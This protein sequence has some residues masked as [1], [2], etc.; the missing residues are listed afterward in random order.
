MQLCTCRNVRIE[1]Q[2]IQLFLAVFLVDR[3]EQHAAGFNAHHRTRGEIHNRHT[4]LTDQLFRLVERVNAGQDRARFAGAVVQREL[5]ELLGLRDCFAV[6]NLDRAEIGLAEGLKIHEV[7]EQRFD[8]DFAEVDLLFG[9]LRCL[10]CLLRGAG[11]A[12]TFEIGGRFRSSFGYAIFMHIIGSFVLADWFHC[13]DATNISEANQFYSSYL[14]LWNFSKQSKSHKSPHKGCSWCTNRC[15]GVRCELHVRAKS[16]V[17]DHRKCAISH[18]T[19][20]NVCLSGENA[21]SRQD[22]TNR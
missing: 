2:K 15:T 1:L 6:Q 21:V 13:R 10:A 22:F 14:G 8:L 11:K 16:D 7:L 9:F 18:A 12:C 4:R 20:L 3:G 19:I 5:Q 17:M